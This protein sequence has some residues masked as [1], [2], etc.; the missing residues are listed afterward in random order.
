MAFRNPLQPYGNNRTGLVDHMIG[1]A[2]KI[3]EYVARHLDEIR[4]LAHNMEAIVDVAN[5]EFQTNSDTVKAVMPARGQT[6]KVPF[7]TGSTTENL[8]AITFMVVTKEGTIYTES[9][10]YFIA[11]ANNGELN[12]KVAS[13]APLNIVG[14]E[15]RWHLIRDK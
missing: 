3:V 11:W 6:L 2:Y 8:N 12:V 10:A 15:I 5:M 4:Y 9:N 7:P 1:N 13:D 14:A